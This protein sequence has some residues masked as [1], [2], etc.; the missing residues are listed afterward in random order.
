MSKTSS[1]LWVPFVLAGLLC[2]GVSRAQSDDERARLHFQAGVSYFEQGRYEDALREWQE[3]YRL[4]DRHVLLMNI[5]Q[6]QERLFQFDEAVQ[7]IERYLQVGGAEAESR[8]NT[9]EARIEA[10]QR[11]GEAFAARQGSSGTEAPPPPPP[12]PANTGTTTPP[13]TSSGTTTTPTETGTDGETSTG[14]GSTTDDTTAEPG[15]RRLWSWVA[16]GGTGLFA[17]GAIITGA[18]ALSYRGDLDERCSSE[19]RCPI[20]LQETADTGHALAI[21]TDVFIGLSAAA[22]VGTV[23]LFIFEGRND[24]EESSTARV[25]PTLGPGHAGLS[26]TF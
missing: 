21:V 3:S 10:L 18:L 20:D 16:L 11:Q 5:S 6:A 12:P 23:L 7:S 4:S 2:P 17:V 25:V 19:L 9:L 15:R 8:R 22:A 24:E 14:D 26:V 13:P 1:L